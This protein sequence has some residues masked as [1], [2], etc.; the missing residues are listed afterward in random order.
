MTGIP[1]TLTRDTYRKSAPWWREAEER[2]R[3]SSLW[4]AIHILTMF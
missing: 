2:V 1:G 3:H 4:D